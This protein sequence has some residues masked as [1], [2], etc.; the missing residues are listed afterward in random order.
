MTSFPLALLNSLPAFR[1]PSCGIA[2]VPYKASYKLPHRALAAFKAKRA[3]LT[4]T[5]N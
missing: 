5:T 1:S 2:S 4:G 3:L